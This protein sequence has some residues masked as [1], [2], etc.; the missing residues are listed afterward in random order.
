M[1]QFLTNPE[2]QRFYFHLDVPNTKIVG[3]HITLTEAYV[4]NKYEAKK[5]WGYLNSND[6]SIQTL[7]RRTTEI[8]NEKQMEFYPDSLALIG[9]SDHLGVKMKVVSNDQ[10]YG[11]QELVQDLNK[12]VYHRLNDILGYLN[13]TNEVVE[14]GHISFTR[15]GS[16]VTNDTA[17]IVQTIKNQN[18]EVVM[19]IRTYAPAI[20]HISISNINDLVVKGRYS[21]VEKEI[22]TK[23][24]RTRKKKFVSSGDN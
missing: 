1:S 9:N 14:S 4:S 24:G 3:A 21:I 6:S 10:K 19:Y 2:Y 13:L 16:K 20:P 7:K 22:P 18:E 5:I 8:L 11:F 12:H 17:W 23:D 15:F